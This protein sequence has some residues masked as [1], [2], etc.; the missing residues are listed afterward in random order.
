MAEVVLAGGHG[1]ERMMASTARAA[2]SRW[3]RARILDALALLAVL[4]VGGYTRLADPI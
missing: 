3:D 2:V 4:V 1:P